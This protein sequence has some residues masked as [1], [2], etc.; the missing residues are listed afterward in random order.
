M[1]EGARHAACQQLTTTPA[2]ALEMYS[3]RMASLAVRTK[4]SELILLALLALSI[5]DW[6]Y[7]WRNNIVL[8]TM[9]WDAATRIGGDAF[10]L[11]EKAASLLPANAAAGLRSFARRSPDLQSLE[12][13]GLAAGS[14]GGGFRY[15]RV[16]LKRGRPQST[17]RD[18]GHRPS[19]SDRLE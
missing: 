5:D 11:F 2:V 7:D 3:E 16:G 10:A 4:D 12:I 6:R 13:M 15:K 17:V 18:E 8:S 14:G 9:Q 1:D 19:R